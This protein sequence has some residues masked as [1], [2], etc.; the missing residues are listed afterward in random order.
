MAAWMEHTLVLY[1]QD[2]S[3]VIMLDVMSINDDVA[4]L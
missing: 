4:L 2:S 3:Y 1:A